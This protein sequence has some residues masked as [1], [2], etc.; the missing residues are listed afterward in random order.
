MAIMG[1]TWDP[2]FIRTRAGMTL[3]VEALVGLVAGLF[4]FVFGIGFESFL[5]WGAAIISGFFLFTHVTNLTQSLESKFPWIMKVHLA[6]MAAWVLGLAI[7]CIYR[8][9]A[10][11]LAALFDWLLLLTFLVDLF[12]KYRSWKSS[13]PA[14]PAAQ[15]TLGAAETGTGGKF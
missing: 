2:A 10:W 15:E 11:S 7:M 5:Y 9:V 13:P 8:F 1:L 6:Y 12:F 3:A 4:G 14:A